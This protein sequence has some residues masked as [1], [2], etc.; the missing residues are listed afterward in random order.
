MRLDLR[1]VGG[2]SSELVCILRPEPSWTVLTLKTE[3]ERVEGTSRRAARLLLGSQVL[4]NSD[5]L[6]DV[7]DF[8]EDDP[9][10]HPAEAEVLLLRASAD[11]VEVLEKVERGRVELEDLDDDLRRDHEIVLAAVSL[12]GIVL[13]NVVDELKRDRE[14]VTA[15][16]RENG[17][18]LRFADPCFQADAEVV[19]AA[20][21][22]DGLALQ[23][24]AHVARADLAL[25]LNAVRQTPKAFSFAAE[26]LQ[27]DY[28]FAL[29][30]V[31][32][33]PQV[34]QYLPVRFQ[35]DREVLLAAVKDFPLALH[36]EAISEGGKL[37][38]D[39]KFILEVMKLNGCAIAYAAEDLRT[40]PLVLEVAVAN[41]KTAIACAK[42]WF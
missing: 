31:R 42:G 20:C 33:R 25:V 13:K 40:D 38:K 39:R 15:A 7:L 23:H 34:F 14:I 29:Q 5:V 3:L 16:V 19:R 22:Q 10:G 1:I 27:S 8:D 35:Q 21:Q 11:W 37:F 26:S 4:R 2:L 28:S 32:S 18:A 41:D 30:A 9:F 6:A 24:A 12:D 36:L 17:A